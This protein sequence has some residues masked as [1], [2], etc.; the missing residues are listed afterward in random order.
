MR[1]LLNILFLSIFSPLVGQI[2]SLDTTAWANITSLDTTAVANIA[3]LDTTSA[4]SASYTNSYYIN[5][6]G[7]PNAD[8]DLTEGTEYD[9]ASG[10][11]FSMGFFFRTSTN[12]TYPITASGTNSWSWY[13]TTSAIRFTMNDGTG[14]TVQDATNY[15]DGSWHHAA[16]V[17]DNS[18]DY[19]Y[20][21]MDG[22]VCCSTAVTSFAGINLSA[23]KLFGLGNDEYTG[24]VDELWYEK[25]IVS[26]SDISSIY[27]SGVTSCGDVLSIRTGVG[28]FWDMED[29][30][31]ANTIEDLGSY[32]NTV[33][34]NA[35]NTIIAH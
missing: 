2:S 23:L 27:G 17:W 22:A 19:L 16:V 34:L 33:L 20:L 4:P 3:S 5:A 9:V 30:S 28:S 24:D 35:H 25:A 15:A 26:G 1:L 7:G 11:S 29:P 21:Y 18:T 13:I 6:T 10:D 14:R 32:A 31:P 8:I 12:G